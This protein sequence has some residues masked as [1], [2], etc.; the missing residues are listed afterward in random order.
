M[1]TKSNI[2]WLII[3]VVLTGILILIIGVYQ[4]PAQN[5]SSS[6]S[7]LTIDGIECNTVEGTNHHIHAHID[8]FINGKPY[9]VPSQIGI[10]PDQKCLYWMHTHD[11]TGIIH[12]ES[13]QNR[14]FTLGQFFDIWNK[15]FN[16][17]QIFENVVNNN[18]NSTLLSVYID[19]KEVNKATDYRNISLG[20]HD[21]I[22]I[23]YGKPPGNI[24]SSYD[25]P[26]GL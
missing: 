11:D 24:P 10:L 7:T 17:N 18:N 4:L 13:P 25:F 12:I 19:G 8:I 21:E 1:A 15:K 9:K 6:P 2:K 14:T 22:A 3:G 16:N 20:P 23:V 5:S 26:E